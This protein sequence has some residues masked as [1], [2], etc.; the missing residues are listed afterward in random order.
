V[1]GIFASVAVLL[2]V[3]GLY[4][5]MA[6]AAQQRTR[7]LGLRIALGATPGQAMAL[8]MRNGLALAAAGI[9]AG[10]GGAVIVGR[11]I[12]SMLYGVSALDPVTFISGPIVLVVVAAVACYAPARRAPA[13]SDCRD[14]ADV[15]TSAL[16]DVDCLDEWDRHS[17]WTSNG[18]TEAL[19]P[20]T[21]TGD[22]P[23]MPSRCAI[24]PAISRSAHSRF[25]IAS[26]VG[27]QRPGERVSAVPASC[28]DRRC[29]LPA[30][31]GRAPA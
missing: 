8:L 16:F 26:F 18:R 28:P 27:Q 13:R 6:F 29:I 19:L 11:L 14:H 3:T 1:L 17:P 20:P 15:W 7:E 24:A 22:A 12:A 9:V 4:A 10:L 31:P 25:G 23:G 5:T 2:A 21:A 30:T